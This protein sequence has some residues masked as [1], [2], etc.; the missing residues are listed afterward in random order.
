MGTSGVRAITIKTLATAAETTAATII[1]L[2]TLPTIIPSTPLLLR[3]P[4][5]APQL[6]RFGGGGTVSQRVLGARW[7]GLP[8]RA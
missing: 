1:A 6:L 3:T 4:Q 8:F 2:H 7:A 5:S